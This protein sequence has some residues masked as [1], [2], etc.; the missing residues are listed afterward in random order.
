MILCF[1]V[2][3]I[4]QIFSMYDETM[5][6]SIPEYMN[7]CLGTVVF[8]IVQEL[9]VLTSQGLIRH[10]SDVINILDLLFYVLFF[11]YYQIRITTPHQIILP[12]KLI[13]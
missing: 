10:Y 6:Y 9:I 8:F 11:F 7:V 13:D 4:L 5:H 12:T 2:P 1:D 3:F